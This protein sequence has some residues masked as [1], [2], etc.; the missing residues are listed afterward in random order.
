[1]YDKINHWICTRS[2]SVSLQS[3][4]G[5]EYT[6][7][8]PPPARCVCKLCSKVVRNA[9]Q[10]NSTG[11]GNVFCKECVEN[12]R[13]SN[14]WNPC[15][16]CKVAYT[17]QNTVKDARM[18]N[19]VDDF[20]VKCPNKDNGCQWKAELKYADNHLDDCPYHLVSCTNGC[21][22]MIQRRNIDRHLTKECPKRSY[23]CSYCN[24]VGEH[25]HITGPGHLDTCPNLLIPCSM[26]PK[27]PRRCNMAAHE[28]K[29]RLEPVPCQYQSVGCTAQPRR[30][31]MSQHNLEAMSDHLQLAVQ[32]IVQ[33]K[34][35]IAQL[36]RIVSMGPRAS[37][38]LKMENVSKFQKAKTAKGRIWHS[39]KF[40]TN[41]MMG[42]TVRLRV[43]FNDADENNKF[44]ACYICVTTG[45]YDTHLEWPFRGARY[46][47]VPRLSRG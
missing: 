36:R 29:C 9:Y 25:Q 46:S 16:S 34:S 11:C 12:H 3:T 2:V 14:A 10:H 13:Q 18:N 5:Y 31:D 26:C 15:P 44:V 17:T 37:V 22:S 21:N 4:G 19:E 8:T 47:L 7:V 6:F 27:R 38:I 35:E 23:E 43:N 42:Y 39:S 32:A 24:E 45:E 1:M 20:V 30:Q 40:F 28:A 41:S 33:Q